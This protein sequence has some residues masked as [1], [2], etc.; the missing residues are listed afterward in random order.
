MS[1][2]QLRVTR[3]N[4]QSTTQSYKKEPPIRQSYLQERT[5]QPINHSEMQERKANPP[6]RVTRE[7][8]QLTTQSYK[9]EQII[10]FL[11]LQ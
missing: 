4:V 5:E 6:L 1:N 10:N 11:K 8:F 9:R 2:Q 7:N 3:K